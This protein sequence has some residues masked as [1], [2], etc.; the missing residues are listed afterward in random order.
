MI[1]ETVS[2]GDIEKIMSKKELKE[3]VG[4]DILI[5]SLRSQL[6]ITKS[7]YGEAIKQIKTQD[8][9]V[10]VIQD[11]IKSSPPVKSPKLISISRNDI[12]KETSVLLLSDA[13]AGEIVEKDQMG[14]ISE[15]NPDIFVKR[16]E[17]LVE[18]TIDLT[19]SKLRGYRFDK[20]VIP[21]LGDM[22]PGIIHQDL[23]E[24]NSGGTIFDWLFLAERTISN[25]IL[26]L[27]KVFNEV[28]FLGVIGNHGRLTKD[29]RFKNSYLN[30]D[31]LVYKMVEKSL[32]LQKNV[33]FFIPKSFFIEKTI[34]GN[35]FLFLHGDNITSW[36]GV[37]YYGID[38]AAKRMIEV[39]ASRGKFFKY[40][41]LGHFHNSGMLDK[42]A[43][44]IILN[45]SIVGPNEF[46]LGKMF[47][48]TEPCQLLFGV[49]EKYGV[50]WRYKIRL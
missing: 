25:A 27:A 5:E 33:K 47:T 20:L 23:I 8:Q 10:K 13:H 40:I 45:G 21:C 28:E 1:R 38:R 22:V 29:I 9:I 2:G 34:E 36:A 11:T 12:V 26:N 41:C 31:Y 15:Y 14:G 43:G 4:R 35:N 18:K 37:P 30:W 42:V 44:E 3:E 19:Q 32:A 39:F 17:R 6:K 46:S 16:C 49:H 48:G 24:Y 50:S 7:K